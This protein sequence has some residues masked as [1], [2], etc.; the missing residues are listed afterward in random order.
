MPQNQYVV[1]SCSSFRS[2]LVGV[3]LHPADRDRSRWPWL[4]LLRVVLPRSIAESASSNHDP[5]APDEPLDPR[6]GARRR[7]R[8][9]AR[10]GRGGHPGARRDDLRLAGG[11][12]Q[13]GL[14]AAARPGPARPQRAAPRPG[15][16]GARPAR[17]RDVRAVLDCGRPIAAGAPR[18]APLGGPLHRLPAARR[19]EPDDASPP[20]PLVGIEAIRAAAAT[21]DGV[22][23]RTPLVG[24]GPPERPPLPEG[25]VPPADRRVQDPRRLRRRRVAP[26]GG[27]RPRRHHLLVGQ[28]RPGRRPRRAPAGRAG[29]R[30]HAVRRAGDQARAGRGG[31]RRDRHR[32]DR[33][34]RAPARRRARSPPSAGS[35]SSRRSTTTGSSP[36]RARSGSRS[37][38]TCP[39]SAASS[40]RSAAAGWRAASRPRSGRSRRRPGSSAWSRSSPPTPGTSL[41]RRRDR[42]AGRPSRSRGRSP[43]G[44]G[45]RRSACGRSPTSRA[46]LDSIVTVSEDEIAAAVRLAAEW[47]RLVVEPS[48]ALSIAALAFRSAELGLDDVDGPV[49]AVVCGGNVDPERYREFLGPDPARGLSAV[50]SDP[51]AACRSLG[52]ARHRVSA[53]ARRAARVAA[54]VGQPLGQAPLADPDLATRSRRSARRSVDE[55]VSR[56]SSRIQPST[57]PMIAARK[58]QVAAEPHDPAG[59]LLVGQRRR[60]PRSRERHVVRVQ[61]RRRVQDDDRQERVLG[62]LEEHVQRSRTGC[63]SRH[64]A[65]SSPTAGHQNSSALPEEQQRARGRGR[66]DPRGRESNSGEKWV[67]HMTPANRT[68]ATTGNARTRTTREWRIGRITRCRTRRRGE[69]QQQRDR[70]AAARGAAPRRASAG[71]AGPCGSRTA[72]CRSAR[73]PTGGR[74]R[75]WRRRP[76]TRRCGDPVRASPDGPR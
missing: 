25:R 76:G 50:R 10:P 5:M 53:R 60:A 65:G 40:S 35:R 74:S 11:R 42:R 27:P 8:P 56:S 4:V 29:G 22:A 75:S 31:R 37:S 44:R 32:R 72:S 18:G 23:A 46:L 20:A 13:P 12:G 71:R 38:R 69:P 70:R 66:A 58:M 16:G 41:A 62:H 34:R 30:R 28:P 57:T 55:P 17:R 61:R 1:P 68:Q 45:R 43:T 39:T 19:P 48:G 51:A 15:R 63:G 26:A 59:Q 49:V 6:A 36:G 64:G 3:D 2:R 52:R 33:Q 67:A 7:A 54:L 21:L 14:R 24:F 9:S 73:S 47:S